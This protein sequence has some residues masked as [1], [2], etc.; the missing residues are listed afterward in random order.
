MDTL[1][2]GRTEY[3]ENFKK[4]IFFVEEGSYGK[5][6]SLIGPNGIGKTTLIKKMA[7]MFEQNTPK[8][9]FYFPTQI[10]GG[11]DFWGFWANLIEDFSEEISDWVLEKRLKEIL[12]ADGVTEEIEF[13]TR[14]WVKKIRDTYEFFDKHG[15][16]ISGN[17]N[18][19]NKA[20]NMIGDI[21]DRYTKLGIRII[22][23][24]D[25]FDRAAKNYKE[26]DSSDEDVIIGDRIFQRLFTL[27]KKGT[28]PL[29]LSI[30]TISRRSVDTIAYNMDDCSNFADAYPPVTLR[31]FSNDELD[32]YFGGY[33][34]L[35]C[36]ELNEEQRRGVLYF[37]GRNP[38]L[39]MGMK[40][41]IGD[42]KG[43]CVDIARIYSESGDFIRTSYKRMRKLM[44]NE[45][46]DEEKSI[47]AMSI[48]FQHFIGPAYTEGIQNKLD[49]LYNYGFVTRPY[50]KQK[51]LFEMSSPEEFNEND[52]V[53]Y[54]P[55]SLFFV[56]FLRD[57]VEV[58]EVSA[59]E[60]IV[61]TT[62]RK[63][64]F[65]IKKAMSEAYPD[66]WVELINQ[67]APNKDGYLDNLRTVALRNHYQERNMTISKLNVIAFHEYKGIIVKYW[68][69]MEKYFSLYNSLDE[70]KSDFDF[71]N[72][73]RN[74]SHHL[75]IE[76][77]ESDERDVLRT[78]CERVMKNIA[79]W[80]TPEASVHE[81]AGPYEAMGEFAVGQIVFMTGY[82]KGPTGGLRGS[83][84]GSNVGVTMSKKYL[85]SIGRTPSSF[86]GQGDI[87][88]K[89]T[90]WDN[91]AQKFNAEL[92]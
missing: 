13:K 34:T 29:N 47:T 72:G 78:V 62:E 81:V 43:D 33:R 17:K 35:P 12:E 7:E 1:F 88:V 80:N 60:G 3:I 46:V 16:D 50:D 28:T 86:A 39:L 8:N 11:V 6:C 83:I 68:N 58:D 23:T 52:M 48:F 84:T 51:N 19:I 69:I 59:L 20:N 4:N 27:S 56:D 82:S 87:K 9:A 15:G 25:E 67:E 89:L 38:G 40:E 70:L 42:W 2:I 55:M 61:N 21:F 65:A 22:I 54:E 44:K 31:G 92:A 75:N 26:V 24:I 10:E 37:C 91:N 41:K 53:L 71:L 73:C 90:R 30:V 5:C 74:T 76:L 85:Q 63:V 32:E 66:N 36:G 45:F 79:A 64:R 77:L 14:T 57:V 49:V 18:L